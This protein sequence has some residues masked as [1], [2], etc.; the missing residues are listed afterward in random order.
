MHDNN[1]T[2]WIFVEQ[3]HLLDPG[4]EERDNLAKNRLYFLPCS[5]APVYHNG[6]TRHLQAKCE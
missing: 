5:I 6:K 2:R 1:P 3:K 4:G